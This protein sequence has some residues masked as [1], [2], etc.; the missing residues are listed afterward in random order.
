M[1]K[2]LKS[3]KNIK[4][5]DNS[6]KVPDKIHISQTTTI[7]RNEIKFSSVD[8]LGDG[9]EIKTEV[10]DQ[11]NADEFVPRSFQSKKIP[12]SIKI[13]L[14][15]DTISVPLIENVAVEE[16]TIFHPNL[17]GDDAVRMEKWVR[18]LFNYRQKMF[19]EIQ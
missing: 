6:N 16:D 10:L 13:D 3:F 12:E 14:N 5:A 2:C 19:A 8:L 18:K 11:I 7:S 1:K 17:Y 9:E 15:T 4:I